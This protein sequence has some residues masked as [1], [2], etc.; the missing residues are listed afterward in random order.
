MSA[1]KN[2]TKWPSSAIHQMT[3][4]KIVSV[5]DF[6]KKGTNFMDI[7]PMLENVYT[8]RHAMRCMAKM[9]SFEFG[10]VAAIES[11]GFILGSNLAFQTYSGF[12][13]IRKKG[14]LPREVHALG[15][16]LEY[17]SDSLEIHKSDVKEDDKVVIVDDVLATG[18]TAYATCRLLEMCGARVIGILFLVEIEGLGGREKLEGY[19]VD[20][21]F[22]L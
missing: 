22:N 15:Y 19:H 20:S 13:P 4:E 18:G 14:K 9:A 2:L 11:R 12:V 16:S 3:L 1:D 6:P 5:P 8:F 10:K 7:T 21:V 17:G